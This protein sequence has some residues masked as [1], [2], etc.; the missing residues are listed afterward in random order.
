MELVLPRILASRLLALAVGLICTV[1][2]AQDLPTLDKRVTDQS[3]TLSIADVQRIESTLESFE[4]ASSNQI[5]VLFVPSLGGESLESYTLRVAEKN[6]LGKKGRSNGVLLLIAKEDRKVRIEVGY[7]LEGALPDA[8]CDQIIRRE[9][10]PRFREG[11]FAG[12]VQAGVNSIIKATRGEFKGEQEKDGRNGN[13]S[14]LYPI[15]L[16]VLFGIFSRLFSGGRRYTVGSRGYRSRGGWW[17][18]GGGFGG[19]SFGSGGGGGGFSGGGGS[20]GGGGAS[21][22]W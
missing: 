16:F 15:I 2:F 3:G 1:G 9:I 8:V 13:N 21:G 18:G 19:G 20:F 6:K 7:G 5:V 17:I 22:S 4:R 12:G 11:D 14:F 10:A